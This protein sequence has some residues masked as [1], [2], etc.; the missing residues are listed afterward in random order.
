M[1]AAIY[2]RKSTE[3]NGAGDK[4]KSAER[5]IAHA[6]ACWGRKRNLDRPEAEWIQ[7]GGGARASHRAM[8]TCGRLHIGAWRPA[9]AIYAA[10]ICYVRFEAM[11]LVSSE[12]VVW[13]AGLRPS[14][15]G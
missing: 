4:S 11:Q 15:A 3:Q 12:I 14:R 7:T 5:Q 8:R 6:R 9:R 13:L 2:A 1:I 10:W